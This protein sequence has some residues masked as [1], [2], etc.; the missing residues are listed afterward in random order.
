M[1]HSNIE[2]TMIYVD[3]APD[4]YGAAWIVNG[5]APRNNGSENCSP[6]VDDPSILPS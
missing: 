3:W 6:A 5:F 2:T 1:G 4:P